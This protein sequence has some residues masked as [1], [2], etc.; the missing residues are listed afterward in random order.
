M[1][2]LALWIKSAELWQLLFSEGRS[3]SWPSWA[4]APRREW[5]LSLMLPRLLFTGDSC[6]QFFILAFRKVIYIYV[7]NRNGNYLYYL[8][9]HLRHWTWNA[10]TD[11]GQPSLG[12]ESPWTKIPRSASR[13]CSASCKMGLIQ[14]PHSLV[15]VSKFQIENF[16]VSLLSEWIAADASVLSVMAVFQSLVNENVKWNKTLHSVK[17]LLETREMG[18]DLKELKEL[19]ASFKNA[20]VRQNVNEYQVKPVY[21]CIESLYHLK[22]L[23]LYWFVL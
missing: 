13:S 7:L 17:L 2:T 14:E 1:K 3:R 8:Q 19:T 4:K 20:S 16:S 21:A 12:L 10:G 22:S 6:Q 11:F 9:F 18:L 15:L 23:I 5:T